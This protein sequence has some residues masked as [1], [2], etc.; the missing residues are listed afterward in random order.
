[1][2]RDLS[3]STHP[4]ALCN[5]T[6]FLPNLNLI[7]RT[8]CS[9]LWIGSCHTGISATDCWGKNRKH[10]FPP[11]SFTALAW[12]WRNDKH[13]E[14]HWVTATSPPH[15]NVGTIYS[16]WTALRRERKGAFMLIVISSWKGNNRALWKAK[17]HPWGPLK[18]WDQLPTMLRYERDESSLRP[19]L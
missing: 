14:T 16:L 2:P 11:A 1:M 8:M 13:F 17:T 5:F 4:Y 19:S 3:R 9:L 6:L 10:T 7:P 12:L 18:H 15:C